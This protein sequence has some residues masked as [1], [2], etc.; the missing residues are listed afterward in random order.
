MA[1]C[2]IALLGGCTGT[3]S[4][5]PRGSGPTPAQA[6][7]PGGSNTPISRPAPVRSTRVL[8]EIS[9]RGSVPYDMQSLP[10]VSPDGRYI[11]TQTQVAPTWPTVAAQHDAQVP[12]ATRVEIYAIDENGV[13]FVAN[14][15][16]PLLLGR[17]FNREGFIVESPNRDGSRW[18]GLASWK[19]GEVTWLVTGEDVNAFASLGPD[20]RLAWNRRRVDGPENAFDLVIRQG[21]QEWSLD[22]PYESWLMPTWSGNG[23]NLFALVLSDEGNLSAVYGTARGELALRQSRRDIHL[24]SD[25]TVYTAYQTIGAQ[26]N[27]PDIPSRE[28]FIFMHPSRAR[29]ALWQPRSGSATMVKF[30]DLNTFAAVLESDEHALV[31]TERQLLRQS[32]RNER[33][34]NEML[35]GVQV[36][37]LT[38]GSQWRYILLS[39]QENVIGITAM[40]RIE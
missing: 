26:V 5:A 38:N 29:M 8:A 39:P 27:S 32:L 14:V 30:F 6:A 36:P 20:G 21:E 1:C 35:A 22:S 4:Q 37:R 11:A 25:A 40:N 2:G 10:L 28:Q 16:E 13:S 23:D 34:R 17:S 31:T 18:I 12:F 7:R 33:D 9:P 19:T 3:P 15:N 24:A